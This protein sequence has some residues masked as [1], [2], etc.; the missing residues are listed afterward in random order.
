MANLAT[1]DSLMTVFEAKRFYHFWRPIHAI[2]NDDKN[3][4]TETQAN[5]SPYVTTPNYPDYPSGFNG[6]SGAMT[7]TLRLF[8]GTDDME[9]SMSGGNG[10]IRQYTS[11]SQAANEVLEVRILQGIHFR[12]AE[13][14]AKKLGEK[15][16]HWGMQKY[17]KATD[18]GSPN[19]AKVQWT[20]EKTK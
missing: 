10:A 19:G 18:P 13:D 20:V 17:M 11:F 14:D 3:P 8:F 16:A 5:W 9:F 12:E 1:S 4:K 7:E 2:R 6:V 15:T